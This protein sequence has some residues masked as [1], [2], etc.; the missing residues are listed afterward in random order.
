MKATDEGS[1]VKSLAFFPPTSALP[2][3]SE[4]VPLAVW[5][6]CSV[7]GSVALQA[8]ISYQVPRRAPSPPTSPPPPIS[9]AD[10]HINHA[11]RRW[12][13][14]LTVVALNSEDVALT[15]T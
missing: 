7:A 9:I 15:T 2:S 14:L 10:S 8:R 12:P 6:H 11:A 5:P 13:D 4:S 1:R 3:H